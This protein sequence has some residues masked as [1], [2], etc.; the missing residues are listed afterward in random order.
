MSLI[1]ITSIFCEFWIATI[2]KPC[3]NADIAG[4]TC[5]Y[6]RE[7]IAMRQ[8]DSQYIQ[9]ILSTG[10]QLLQVIEAGPHTMG[11]LQTNYGTQ[12]MV[13]TPLRNIGEYVSRLSADC[14]NRCPDILWTQIAD[15][16]NQLVHDYDNVDWNIIGD[17]VFHDLPA[18]LQQL[19]E[20]SV[21]MPD[22]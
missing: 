13:A 15:V 17:I 12:W 20:I 11:M 1:K 8:T 5:H 6:R 4:K 21:S 19:R 22:E 10:A 16:Q 7:Q 2:L 18:F 14:K 3:Y 9:K